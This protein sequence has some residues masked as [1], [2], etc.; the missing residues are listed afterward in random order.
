M[1]GTQRRR[2]EALQRAQEFVK[3]NDSTLLAGERGETRRRLFETFHALV[4]RAWRAAVHQE[5]GLRARMEGTQRLRAAVRTLRQRHLKPLSQIST[6]CE[7]DVPGIRSVLGLPAPKIS[8]TS[9]VTQADAVREQA[10]QHQAL[11]VAMGR[12]AGFVTQLDDAIAAVRRAQRQRDR[13]LGLQVGATAALEAHLLK[14]RRHLLLLENIV[15]E[16]YQEDGAR[17]AEWR[18]AKRVQRKPGRAAGDTSEPAVE[19][20]LPATEPTPLRLVSVA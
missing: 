12:D 10:A 4:G 15:A 16:V 20:A 5:Y 8:V 9:L 6:A 19:A 2:L 1:L 17:L 11:L 14:A 7:V 3:R 18:Q 13:A